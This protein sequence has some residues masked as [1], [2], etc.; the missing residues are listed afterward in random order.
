LG[1]GLGL[2]SK[3]VDATVNGTTTT[4]DSPSVFASAVH[5]GVPIV[6]SRGKHY[7]FE[8]T[9][10]A[11][12]G[13]A[14]ATI[15]GHGGASDTSLSATRVQEGARL[16]R[17]ILFGFI[18][19]PE[20]G[21][22]SSVGLQLRRDAVK[23]SQDTPSQSAGGSTMTIGSTVEGAPWAIFVNNISAIYYF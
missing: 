1:L 19:V 7:A 15:K 16:G 9:P 21:L 18:G 13:F 8:L 4:Q 20:L 3:S 10:E 14:Q 22:Q 6:L 23:E 2:T 12:I 5:G 11:T 17:A